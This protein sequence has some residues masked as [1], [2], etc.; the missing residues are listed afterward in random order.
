MESPLKFARVLELFHEYLESDF[1]DLLIKYQHILWTT[2]S[3]ICA[4][5]QLTYVSRTS[6]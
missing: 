6:C 3:D 1:H 2:N 5:T 4:G